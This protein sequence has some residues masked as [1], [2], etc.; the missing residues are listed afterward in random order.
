VGE[1]AQV[2]GRRPGTVSVLQHRALRRLARH[3][4]LPVR[5]PADRGES[6]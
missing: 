4:I 2:T 5:E 6:R 1:V 3:F